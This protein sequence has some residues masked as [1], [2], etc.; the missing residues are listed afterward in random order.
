MRPFY[1]LWLGQTFSICGSKLVS[2]KKNKGH[3]PNKRKANG[4]KHKIGG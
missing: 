3:Y 1:Q 2:N 4:I